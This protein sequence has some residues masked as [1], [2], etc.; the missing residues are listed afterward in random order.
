MITIVERI[1][2]IEKE[3]LRLEGSLRVYKELAEKSISMI[4][5]PVIKKEPHVKICEC[6]L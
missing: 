4:L 2:E 6:Q 1:S 3:I 5:V